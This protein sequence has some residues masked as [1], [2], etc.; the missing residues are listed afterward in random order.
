MPN[1]NL[2]ATLA[3][4]KAYSTAR[5]QTAST[6]AT[7]D[8]V[9]VDLLEAASRYLD[10]KTGRFYFP[11]IETRLYDVPRTRTLKLRADLLSVITLSNG[12]SAAIASD[13]YVLETPNYTPYWK[14]RLRDT[15]TTYWLPNTAN[16]VEQAISLN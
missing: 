3:D 2:Y 12:D 9:V 15:A 13:Q 14:L 11:S 5:G 4:Y 8:G 16:G 10:E 7:D 1:Y 6:D